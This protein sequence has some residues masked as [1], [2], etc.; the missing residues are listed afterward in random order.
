MTDEEM[1]KIRELLYAEDAGDPAK[2]LKSEYA[3]VR[4]DAEVRLAARA[5]LDEVERL[6]AELERE[7]EDR[8]RE[9]EF[10]GA[11]TETYAERIRGLIA[12]NEALREIARAV[13]NG[14]TIIETKPGVTWCAACR[15]VWGPDSHAV[16]DEMH[17]D[18][19]PVT[20][21]HAVLAD[22]AESVS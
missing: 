22:N 10:Y 2:H 11:D 14:G 15:F 18:D 5:L 9:Y 21:A 1:A 8:T 7:R 16:A 19:C 3:S 13:A 17:A 6:G 20:K 12:E 4:Y